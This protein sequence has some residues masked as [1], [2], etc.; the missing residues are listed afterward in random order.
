LKEK[1]QDNT[2]TQTI[3]RTCKRPKLAILSLRIFSSRFGTIYEFDQN[4]TENASHL[5]IMCATYDE[6]LVTSRDRRRQE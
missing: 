3:R 6:M 5:T 4:V 1:V 2:E